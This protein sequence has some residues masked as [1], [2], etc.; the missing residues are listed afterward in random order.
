[1]I[2]VSCFSI[3]FGEKNVSNKRF[4]KT[5]RLGS[6]KMV[7]LEGRS[8]WKEYTVLCCSS[9]WLLFSSLCQRHGGIFFSSLGKPGRALESKSHKNVG[10]P[11]SHKRFFS[12]ICPV[13]CQLQF[14]F[15][16]PALVSRAFC[17]WVSA[18][19]SCDSLFLPVYLQFGGSAWPNELKP[20]IEEKLL[21][22]SDDF[23]SL[24]TGI[25]KSFYILL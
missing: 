1:M 13:V 6:N 4:K 7:S 11:S 22:C 9:K 17:S 14:G 25:W 18:P 2:C 16:Y 8:C 23:Q 21:G 10:P 12:L 5:N 15:F 3:K 24:Q 20:L 19:I